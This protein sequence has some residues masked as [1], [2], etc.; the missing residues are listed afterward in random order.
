VSNRVTGTC[1]NSQLFCNFTRERIEA[2]K[3]QRELVRVKKLVSFLRHSETLLLQ[4]CG[5]S[6]SLGEPR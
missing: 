2:E 4:L 3:L 1:I 5:R 6:P